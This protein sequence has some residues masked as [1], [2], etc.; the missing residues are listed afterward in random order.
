MRTQPIQSEMR[1]ASV[2]GPTSRTQVSISSN[3]TEIQSTEQHRLSPSYRTGH[4]HQ[5]TSMSGFEENCPPTLS[6]AAAAAARQSAAPA[7]FSWDQNAVLSGLIYS[8]ILGKPKA[9]RGR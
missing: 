6:P 1:P 8:E 9:L 7:A 2:E 5:E 4:A 3:L